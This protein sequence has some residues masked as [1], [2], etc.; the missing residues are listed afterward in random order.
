LYGSTAGW[1]RTPAAALA[2]MIGL[3]VWTGISARHPISACLSPWT[4]AYTEA[5][6]A[7]GVSHL[8]HAAYLLGLS[9]MATM[10]A[11]LRNPEG[12]R[13]LVA[14]TAVVVALTALAGWAQLP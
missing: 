5:K 11:L 2:V 6:V 3:V 8:W 13:A 14:P 12:R 1:L 7:A 10:A 4:L 9:V